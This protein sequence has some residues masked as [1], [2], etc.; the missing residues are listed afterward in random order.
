MMNGTLVEGPALKEEPKQEASI[1]SFP[2]R[3]DSDSAIL[4]PS[5]DSS[6]QP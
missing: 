4:E 1:T 6:G 5:E 2:V 3:G